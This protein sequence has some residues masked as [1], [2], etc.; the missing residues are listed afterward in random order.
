MN[1]QFVFDDFAAWV[2][3]GNQQGWIT[4][5][6]C[7]FHDKIPYTL[8]QEKLFDQDIEVCCN[9]LKLSDVVSMQFSECGYC[10]RPIENGE[11]LI[12]SSYNGLVCVECD[13]NK[14]WK[15]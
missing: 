14:P 1:G 8:E 2:H 9:V 12:A 6:L 5:P 3:F 10:G 4:Q 7:I 13:L 11:K 15:Y